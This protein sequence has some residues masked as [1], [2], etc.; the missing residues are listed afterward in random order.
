MKV[1]TKVRLA[2]FAAIGCC[3]MVSTCSAQVPEQTSLTDYLIQDVCVDASDRVLADDPATCP[4]KRN[5]KIGEGLPYLLTDYDRATGQTFQAVGSV[6][7]QGPDGQRRILI[8]KSLE[9]SFG[10]GYTFNFRPERDA[11]DLIDISSS[12]YASVIRTFDGGCYDQMFSHDGSKAT[13][14]NRAGGWIL[15]PLQPAPAAWQRIQSVN[16]MTYRMQLSD[17]GEACRDNH[18]SGLTR[19]VSPAKTYFES[20][21]SLN[22]IRSDHFASANL[23]QAENSF[24][25]NYFTREYGLTRWEAWQT[26]AYCQKTQGIESPNCRPGDTAN[27]WFGRC[28]ALKDETTGQ[29]GS[30]TIGGQSWVRVMCRDQTHFIALKSQQKFLS[31]AIAN[32]NGQRDIDYVA[33]KNG[34]SAN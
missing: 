28:Q 12:R 18:A 29:A 23:D 25:R 9:G 15:F 6:P 27:P 5:L 16:H 34:Y 2:A 8:V 7:V 20:G 11:F 24:E 32:G 33:T 21:K 3:G 14:A 1:L 30:A 19:W 22:A 26:L 4:A 10:P 31:S 17:R 13:F